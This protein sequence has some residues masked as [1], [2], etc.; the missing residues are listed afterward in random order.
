MVNTSGNI[1]SHEMDDDVIKWKHFPRYW[2]IGRGIHRSPVNS[3]HKS[4]WRR[5]LVVFICALN[6]RLSNQSWGWW[7]KTPAH[8]LWR[9]SNV[10]SHCTDVVWSWKGERINCGKKTNF[11]NWYLCKIS[12]AWVFQETTV[13]NKN[14]EMQLAVATE[15]LGGF[16][17]SR[18]VMICG[19][20]L[21]ASSERNYTFELAATSLRDQ[22]FK[23][24]TA[25]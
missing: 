13:N 12:T 18:P 5:A 14:I 20:H 4:Q 17:S 23:H 24:W 3:P 16:S 19:I 8:P 2:Q 22:R 25:G 9:H 11:G 1:S 7:F 21:R 15:F 6:K 10:G